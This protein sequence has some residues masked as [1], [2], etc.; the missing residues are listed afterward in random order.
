MVV[1][2]FA[3]VLLVKRLSLAPLLAVLQLGGFL[4]LA[5]LWARRSGTD[6]REAFW[7]RLPSAQGALAV[8]LLVPG[9]LGMQGL[10]RRVLDASWLPGTEEFLRGLDGMMQQT[11]SWPLP[12][13]LTVIALLPAICEEAAFRGVVLAG[14]SRTG[15]RTVAVVGSALAFGLAHVHPVHVLIAGAL[16][17]VMGLATLRTGSILAGVV[18]HLVNNGVSVLISRSGSV[19]EWLYG[20]PFT[21]ALCVPG[22]VGLWLLHGASGPRAAVAAAPVD[23]VAVPERAGA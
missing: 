11:Q 3:A 12:L 17:L 5:V 9:V 8:L 13:A 10:L 21:V 23:A 18:L 2:L 4:G 19:P 7:L 6:L 16:G 15:S 14:L 1:Y 22:L 20:W